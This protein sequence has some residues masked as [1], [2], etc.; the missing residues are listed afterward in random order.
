M[1]VQED[2]WN[3]RTKSAQRVVARSAFRAGPRQRFLRAGITGPAPPG[4]HQPA[5]DSS[6]GSRS[7]NLRRGAAVRPRT[8]GGRTIRVPAR[9][10]DE[11]LGNQRVVS[12]AHRTG[13]P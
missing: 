7:A 4:F 3:D 2:V 1:H 12:W 5:A 9:S 6:A 13:G 11:D 8:A 10:D